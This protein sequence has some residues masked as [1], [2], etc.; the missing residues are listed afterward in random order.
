MAR[1]AGTAGAYG[2]TDV[3]GRTALLS[4]TRISARLSRVDADTAAYRTQ[5]L[6][7]NP[8]ISLGYNDIIFS[9]SLLLILE[10]DQKSLLRSI[11]KT[12]SRAVFIEGVS[13]CKVWKDLYLPKYG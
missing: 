4:Y 9:Y 10:N 5:I 1:L 8:T 2:I 11:A 7:N 6:V 3:S 12:R 13:L